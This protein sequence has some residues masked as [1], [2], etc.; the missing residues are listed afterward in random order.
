MC[1]YLILSIFLSAPYSFPKQIMYEK[2]APDIKVNIHHDTI[3]IIHLQAYCTKFSRIVR[4]SN[5][6]FELLLEPNNNIF[7]V[8]FTCC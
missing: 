7:K 2:F 1:N 8:T 4:S 3:I 6:H 5:Y